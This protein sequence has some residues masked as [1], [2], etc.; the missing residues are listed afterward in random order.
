MEDR[1]MQKLPAVSGGKDHSRYHFQVNLGGMLDI[2]S[3]HLYKSQDVFIRELL[4]NGVDAITMRQKRQEEWNGGSISITIVPGRQIAFSDNGAGLTEEEIHRF[5]AVI[6]SSSKTQIVNGQIPEDYIGRFGIGL[7]SCFMVSDSIVVHTIP[8]DGSQ[9]NVWTGF[10]D[11]TYTLEPLA[12]DQTKGAAGTTVILNAKKGEEHYFQNEKVAE[13]VQYYGLAL[14]VPVYLSGNPERL[15][16]VPADFSGIGRSQL[17]SFGNWL[18]GDDFLDGIPIQTPHLSGVA[19]ILPYRTDSSMKRGH[20]IYLKHMLLTE[21]GNTLLPSWAFFLRCFLNTQNLRPTAS[22]E[23]F[24]EDHAL[25]EAREE[26]EEAVRHYLERLAQDSPE[27]LTNIVNTHVEAIKSMAVWDDRM[28]H[29]FIDYLSF[30]TSEGNVTGSFLKHAGEAEWVSSVPRFQQ[31]KPLFIAQGRLLICTGYMHDEE[32]I[33][34]LAKQFDLPLRPFQ[35]GSMD[36][37]LEEL[38]AFEYQSTEFF[39]SIASRVLKKFDCQAAVRRFLPVDLPVLYSMSD[40]IQFL[41]QMQSAR[42]NTSNLFSDA[43]SSL[44]NGVEEKPLATIYF[45]WNNPLIQRLVLQVTDETLL[46]SLIK[47]L[48][49]QALLAGGYPL[50]GTVLKI[51]NEELLNLVEYRL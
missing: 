18:F 12:R 13:L 7:L 50:K 22:R 4:Q 28:F 33:R 44:I 32:L 35:E 21:E 15:N 38:N 27:R 1:E 36:L 10:P 34:K 42:E 5:L 43:L 20:R 49:V 51:L 45:N 23:D 24:Y 40:E 48:Y 25:T 30:E 3:N 16:Y 2:L 9:A 14:P 47:V 8:E 46:K 39:A 6:G 31:L 37:V 19:Y 17:L 11:G 26:F 41:R 29:L